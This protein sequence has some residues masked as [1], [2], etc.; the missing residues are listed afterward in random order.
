MPEIARSDRWKRY[1]TGERIF[2]RNRVERLLARQ[3]P[4]ERAVWIDRMTLYFSDSPQMLAEARELLRRH[5]A[6]RHPALPFVLDSWESASELCWVYPAWEGVPLDSFVR[7]Q[8]PG[9]A[10]ALALAREAGEG[11]AALHERNLP[12]GALRLP[13]VMLIARGRAALTSTGLDTQVNALL[14]RASASEATPN[15]LGVTQESGMA[16]DIAQWG[17]LL[18][19]LLAGDPDFARQRVA[20]KPTD[21]LDLSRA[22]ESLEEAEVPAAAA[23]IVMKALRAGAP[24]GGEAYATLEGA[25]AELRRLA[26]TE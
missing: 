26:A 10:E 7:Q 25:L 22:E 19:A 14:D 20:G 18:G 12:H 21:A 9:M 4:T 1:T 23:T 11:L 3:A 16:E 13:E 8:R 24:G 2:S 15:L 6:V 5:A 17:R